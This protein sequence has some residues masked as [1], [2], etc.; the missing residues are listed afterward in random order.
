MQSFRLVF[1]CQKE[2]DKYYAKLA[3]GKLDCVHF[4]LEKKQ[5]RMRQFN[6]SIVFNKGHN[7]LDKER[8]WLVSIPLGL[9]S[10]EHWLV[11]F[12]WPRN[13]S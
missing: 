12:T 13:R 11:Q 9:T 8:L 10:S 2:K 3:Q 5:E 1:T 7:N 4:D 6:I